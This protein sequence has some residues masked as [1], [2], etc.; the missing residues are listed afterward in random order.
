MARGEQSWQ[1]RAGAL[2]AHPAFATL[3]PRSFGQAQPAP[4]QTSLRERLQEAIDAIDW[5]PDLGDAIGSARW[6]RG[7][8]TLAL[9]VTIAV[10]SWPG[11]TPL[12]TRTAALPDNDWAAVRPIGIAPLAMGAGSG[13]RMMPSDRVV[14]LASAPERPRVELV[15]MLGEGDEL[16]RALQRAGVSGDDAL[17]AAT[18]IAG[19]TT[20][21]IPAG[22]RIDLVLG[23]R[24]SAMQPRSLEEVRLRAALDLK[25][26]VRRSGGGLQLER[27]AVAVSALPLRLRIAVGESIY[28]SARGAGLPPSAIQSWLRAINGAVPIRDLARSDT[29]DFIVEQRRAATGEIEYGPLLYAG[30]DR[31]GGMAVRMIPWPV[32]GQAQWLE[33]GHLG[34][35]RSALGWPVAGRLTSPFGLRVHPILRFA[36]MHSGID[37]GA[38][39]GTPVYAAADGVVDY[40]G[41]KGGYGRFVRVQ[42]GE[43]LATAYAHMSGIA[44]GGGAFVRKGQ[45]VG[46][47]GSTGLSTGPHLHYE[48]YRDGRAVNPMKSHSVSRALLSADE[49]QRFMARLDAMA[50]LPVGGA[51]GAQ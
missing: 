25:L 1:P 48:V 44:T 19:A 8:A 3:G 35:Q 15:A 18:L 32:N 12:P 30:L 43:G 47:V 23:K 4:V 6:W 37:I 28:R 24:V 14:P 40:A 36:R 10:S 38:P 16:T 45:L 29:A 46:Y 17:R 31:A 42:H 49:Q 22:T 2:G 34:E 33:A 51:G 50:R 7:V 27:Q 26:L 13:S 5:T 9:L 39:W 21:P 41:Y 20:A 11:V